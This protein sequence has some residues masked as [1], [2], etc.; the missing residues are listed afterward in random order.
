LKRFRIEDYRNRENPTPGKPYRPEILTH[1]HQAKEL[2]GMFGL[3]APGNQVVYHYHEN[4][5]SIL[6][7]IGGE[8]IEVVE[9]EEISIREGDILFIPSG[10]KHML[11]NRSDKDLRYLEFFT[12][13]PV[14]ADFVEVGDPG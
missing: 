9:G 13:P 4:R 5:E 8:G 1:K 14:S 11:L 7:V 10:E 6:I 12:R 3:L 2:G